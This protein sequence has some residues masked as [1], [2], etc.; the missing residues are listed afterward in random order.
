VQ[1]QPASNGDVEARVDST[2]TESTPLLSDSSVEEDSTKSK[3]L[4]S[5]ESLGPGFIWIQAGL[6]SSILGHQLRTN[7]LFSYILQRLPLWI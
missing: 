3:P 5:Q 1:A 4:W 2:E 7:D 6:S